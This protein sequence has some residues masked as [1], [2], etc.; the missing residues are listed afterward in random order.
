MICC[1][2]S[3]SSA[4]ACGAWIAMWGGGLGCCFSSCSALLRSGPWLELYSRGRILQ[5]ALKALAPF[6]KRGLT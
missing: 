3:S 2:I 6:H 1:K 5:V 4:E